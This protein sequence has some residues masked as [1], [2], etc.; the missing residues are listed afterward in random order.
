MNEAI[1]VIL[2]F[3]T[4][5]LLVCVLW[6]VFSSTFTAGKARIAKLSLKIGGAKLHVICGNSG[7]HKK[8]PGLLGSN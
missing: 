4:M 5:V 1:W 7:G 8:R 6:K 3:I 2:F